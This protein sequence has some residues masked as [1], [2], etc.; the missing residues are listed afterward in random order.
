M[1]CR[2]S[3]HDLRRKLIIAKHEKR[4][5]NETLMKLLRPKPPS[6]AQPNAA[7]IA[8]ART[9]KRA[10]EKRVRGITRAAQRH[11]IISEAIMCKH[12]RR[13]DANAFFR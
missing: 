10:A 3:A 5:A 2:Q 7:D 1:Y 11:T 6:A 9:R 8:A 12:R 13:I 4:A